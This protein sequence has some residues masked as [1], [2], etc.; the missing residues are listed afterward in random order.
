M[1]PRLTGE[2]RAIIEQPWADPESLLR[3]IL[4][5]RMEFVREHQQALRVVLQELPFHPEVRQLAV[6]A[7]QRDIWP[8]LEATW[9]RLRAEGKVV[10]VP[11]HAIM[12]NV[13]GAFSAW[14]MTRFVVFPTHPWDEKQEAEWLLR[15]LLDG[16]RTR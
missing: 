8:Q 6:A 2:V 10:D 14:M 1:A 7:V 12:R 13:V 3:A 16:I 4:L 15:L 5:N 11:T 9:D